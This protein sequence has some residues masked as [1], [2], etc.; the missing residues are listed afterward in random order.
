VTVTLLFDIDGTLVRTGGAGK[1]AMEMALRNGFGI[2]DINDTVPY[3]GRTDPAITTDLLTVHDIAP[4]PPNLAR[5]RQHYLDALPDALQNRPGHVCPG[6]REL[7]AELQS[8]SQVRLGLLTGNIEAGAMLK[9]Q[10]FDLWKPFAFGGFGDKHIDR[11]EVAREAV[12][13]A[14]AKYGAIDPATIWVIGDT[15]HDVSAGRAIGAKTLAVC[16]GWEKREDLER[17]APDLLLNDLS[18]MKL[19]PGEWF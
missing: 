5:L 13:E 18:Q 1:A 12:R 9:L 3:S 8:T 16:T 15:P 17:C 6:V 19:L 2:R 4:T 14:E 11:A 10:S 7:I